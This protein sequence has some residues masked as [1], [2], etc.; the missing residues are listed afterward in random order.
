MTC[1]NELKWSF[2]VAAAFLNAS[3]LRISSSTSSVPPPASR[4]FGVIG[5]LIVSQDCSVNPG[6][7]DCSLCWAE[8]HK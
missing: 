1:R 5:S 7:V 3:C 8:G 2:H 6:W 4:V